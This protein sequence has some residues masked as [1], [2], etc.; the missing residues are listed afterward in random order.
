[1]SSK[2]LPDLMTPEELAE[3]WDMSVQALSQLRYR[4]TGPKFVRIG[5]KSI[6][7]RVTDVDAY[8]QGQTYQRT[9]VPVGGEGA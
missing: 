7:Y 4:G 2:A 3:R 5:A 9:D 1:M 6:R 8:E